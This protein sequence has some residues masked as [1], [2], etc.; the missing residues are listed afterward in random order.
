MKKME[1]EVSGYGLVME[2][3]LHITVFCCRM[4]VERAGYSEKPRYPGICMHQR[5]LGARDQPKGS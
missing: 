3:M 2:Y 4:D 5:P 1:C